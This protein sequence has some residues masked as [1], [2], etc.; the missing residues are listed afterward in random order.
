MYIFFIGYIEYIVKIYTEILI[1]FLIVGGLS[2]GELE[3]YLHNELEDVVRRCG[4]LDDDA[5]RDYVRKGWAEEFHEKYF[6][7][8]GFGNSE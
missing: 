7:E 4:R 5:I 3:D 1:I 6:K 8:S 2:K